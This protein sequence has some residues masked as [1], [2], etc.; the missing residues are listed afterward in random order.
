M[1]DEIDLICDRAKGQIAFKVGCVL[2]KFKARI[3]LV[4]LHS[5]WVKYESVHSRYD[6]NRRSTGRIR[7]FARTYS[8]RGS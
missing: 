6:S 3:A 2:G 5:Y 7:S 8:G 4:S 1:N